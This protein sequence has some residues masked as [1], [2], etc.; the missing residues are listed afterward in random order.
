MNR[1]AVA[2]HEEEA[3]VGGDDEAP[4]GSRPRDVDGSGDVRERSPASVTGARNENEQ[5]PG[6]RG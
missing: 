6:G 5:N 1:R 2:A 4:V 3:L